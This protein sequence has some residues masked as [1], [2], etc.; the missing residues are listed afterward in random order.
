MK[1]KN[2]ITIIIGTLSSLVLL[3]A[4]LK[5]TPYMDVSN[6]APIVQFGL[7]IANGQAGPFQFAGDT[8]GYTVNVYDTAIAID[9]SSPQ[10]L[11]DTITV[12]FQIDPTQITAFNGA[13]GTN[14][15]VMPAAYYTL[16]DTSVQILPG[17]RV[18]AIPVTFNINA[19]PGTH[20]YAFPLTI[21]SVVD[22]QNPNNQIIISGNSNQFMW[23]FSR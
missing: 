12:G 13:N 5:D 10:V 11:N 19:M 7:S 14:F 23:L 21:T 1:L 22:K 6:T 16:T 9:L 18:A 15:V 2:S 8:A 17:H 3:S 20:N 4:C